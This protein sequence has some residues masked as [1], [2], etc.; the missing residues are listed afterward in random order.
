MKSTA[1][2]ES[3]FFDPNVHTTKNE[4]TNRTPFEEN[5]Y[6]ANT[7]RKNQLINDWKQ[8]TSEERRNIKDLRRYFT[9]KEFED[10]P[11]NKRNYQVLKEEI[12]AR[13]AYDPKKRILL[14]DSITN[15]TDIFE[16]LHSL[17]DIDKI[18]KYTTTKRKHQQMALTMM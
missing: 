1:F 18:K 2:N 11:S 9:L 17:E 5:D 6:L 13:I 10:L 8:L 12:N 3:N 7:A 16:L 15:D 14:L 4:G